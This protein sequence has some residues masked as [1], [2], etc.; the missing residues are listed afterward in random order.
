M[1]LLEGN[2]PAERNK[3][4]AAIV[5]GGVALISISYM[6]L[7]SSTP[8]KKSTTNSNSPR[9]ATSPTPRPPVG[10][11]A[12]QPGDEEQ[13]LDFLRPVN[14][15]ITQPSIP[16]AGRNIFDYYEGP[17]PAP[18]SSANTEPTLPPTPTPVPP[19][20]MLASVSPINVYARTGDFTLE[21]TGDKFTPD[22]RIEIN[23][24]QLPT[25]FINAQQL[26]ASVSGSLIS[27]EGPR[28]ISVRS[29]DGQLFSNTATLNVQAPP[30]PNYTFVGLIAKRSYNDTALLKDRGNRDLLSVQRGDLLGGRFRITSI[31]ER[32]VALI[33]TNL[34]IKHSLPLTTDSSGGSSSPGSQ[35]VAPTTGFPNP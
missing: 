20:V 32:E 9:A 29:P 31:S 11:T 34:K 12:R 28:T 6:L 1:A 2:T 4:I 8:A 18:K 23:G 27:F 26:S 16:E 19:N 30:T 3:T 24:T 10:Q 25:R 21:V 13:S 35:P 33:D 17:P 7:G 14:Y 15:T 22:V 5:L